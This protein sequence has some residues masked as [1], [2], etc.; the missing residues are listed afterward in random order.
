MVAAVDRHMETKEGMEEGAGQIVGRMEDI[1]FRVFVQLRVGDLSDRAVK[2]EI[3]K[4]HA[5]A[6]AEDGLFLLKK[7][8]QRA[9]LF[10]R[11]REIGIG[12]KAAAG[13]REVRERTGG[14]VAVSSMK[15]VTWGSRRTDG[16]VRFFAIA[17]GR[18]QKGHIV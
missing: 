15:S 17:G 7:Q 12:V 1:L 10:Y 18:L 11:E 2:I 3:D 16:N 13:V 6:D 8:L 14:A 5:L 4:L 9:E